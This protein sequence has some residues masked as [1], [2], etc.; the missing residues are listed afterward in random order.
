MASSS[1]SVE[2]LLTFAVKNAA[3]VASPNKQE[4]DLATV[5][6]QVIGGE[7]IC[8]PGSTADFAIPF[9]PIT[10]GKRIYLKTDQPVTLKIGLITETGFEW[11]GFGVIPSGS[12]GIAGMWITTGPTDTNV[13][14]VVAGD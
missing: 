9:A 8:I 12:T 14:F 2:T 6:S 13:E 1:K 7:P 3:G 10:T 4:K 5:V 11:E